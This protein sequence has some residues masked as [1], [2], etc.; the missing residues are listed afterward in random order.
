MCSAV[1]SQI[2]H[3]T[4]HTALPA[5]LSSAYLVQGLEGPKFTVLKKIG[6][7]IELRR[8]EPGGWPGRA[9]CQLAQQQHQRQ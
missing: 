5:A 1:S 6:D 2:M 8:Y 3:T 4:T 7:N 9:V